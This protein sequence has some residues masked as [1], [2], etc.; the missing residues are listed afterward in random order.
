MKRILKIAAA[1]LLIMLGSSWR[2]DLVAQPYPPDQYQ[3][4]ND[5]NGEV[6]FQTF[7]DELS[8]H[9]QWVDHPQHGYVWIPDAG[10]DFRPYGSNGHWVYTDDYE[11][12]WVSDFDWGWAP[13]HYGRWDQDP[14]YGWL[15][16]P[17][18]DWSPAW[19]AW[20]DGGDYYGW[21]PIRPGI[22]VGVNFSI[23]TYAPP[24][25]FWSFAPRRYILYPNI[26]SYFIDRRQNVTIIRQTTIITHFSFNRNIFITGPRRAHF[27]VYTGRIS[28]VRIV[29]SS[30]RGRNVF[31][32]NQVNVYRPVVRRFDDR[33]FAPRQFERYDRQ[34]AMNNRFERNN[35]GRING[36]N[37]RF[38]N[39]NGRRDNNFR[40][41]NN[42]RVQQPGNRNNDRFNRMNNERRN[43]VTRPQDNNRPQQRNGN[44]N[45]P[46]ERRNDV[47]PQSNNNGRVNDPGRIRPFERNSNPQP[48]QRERVTRPAERPNVGPGNNNRRVDRPANRPATQPRQEIRRE[49]PQRPAPRMNERRQEQPRQFE[50][51]ENSNQRRGGEGNNGRGNGRGR[52]N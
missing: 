20:R 3:Q 13:F 37:D 11:W 19:V 27:E 39:N 1:A 48:G 9:G 10:P 42:N 29:Q 34:R 28:P 5:N 14:Y 24:Y 44:I 2:S 31:I 7:Y 38:R 30:R 18:Y 33:R 50:R 51:R 47:R 16:V 40:P 21:A 8:P 6:T 36:N 22:N 35:N 45:R 41:G 43:P 4:Y 25:D 46:G 17:G 52:G 15:W 23:G 49:T 32:N 12:M 26:H